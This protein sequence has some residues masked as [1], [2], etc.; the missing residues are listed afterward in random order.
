MTAS[1]LR[2]QANV[3][4]RGSPL[5]RVA[6]YWQD[7]AQARHAPASSRPALRAALTSRRRIQR[8]SAPPRPH[9]HLARALLAGSSEAGRVLA[10]TSDPGCSEAGRTWSVTRAGHTVLGLPA[11][12]P[13]QSRAAQPALATPDSFFACACPVP[14]RVSCLSRSFGVVEATLPGSRCRRCRQ[15][16][17]PANSSLLTARRLRPASRRLSR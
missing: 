17:Q 8:C 12:Y 5:H 7:R 15:S 13:S 4:R 3:A 9:S 1:L 14:L 2:A 11:T 16:V 6:S 10:A